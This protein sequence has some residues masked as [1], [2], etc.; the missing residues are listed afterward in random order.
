MQFLGSGN[1]ASMP[2]FVLSPSAIACIIGYFHGPDREIPTPAEDYRKATIDLI[3]PAYNEQN[4]VA[5]CLES[6]IKQTVKPRHIYLIDDGS[7]DQTAQFATEY[8]DD[9]GLNLT[10][11]SKK[12]REGKTPAVSWAAHESDADVLV[13]LDADTTLRSENY[14]ERLVQELYQGVGIACACGVVLPE[15]ERDRAKLLEQPEIQD[16][17]LNHPEIATSQNQGLIRN[18]LLLLSNYYREELYLYLQKFIYHGEMVFFGSII[19]P[20]GCAVAYR[21]QYI[22]DI[23]DHYFAR[24][25]FNLTSSEDIFIGFAFADKGYRNIQLNDVYALTTEPRFFQMPKQIKMWSSAFLQSCY[26]FD[27]LVRTPLKAP[28]KWYHAFKNYLNPM[29]PDVQKRRIIHEAY[30]QSFNPTITK[31]YGRPIG[32]FI[33]TSLLEKISYP[34]I[35]IILMILGY[36]KAIEITVLAEVTIYTIMIGFMH[37]NRRIRNILK[38]LLMTPIRYGYLAFDMLFI[39]NF[40]KELWITKNREWRK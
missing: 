35:L 5:L 29:N 3:I 40:A 17:L 12:T 23:F 18:T 19:N 15:F 21:R 16:F 6:V 7:T 34:T 11:L 30:R 28:K 10:V 24:F 13:V 8:A 31:A 4:N 22:L 33:F 37:K 26:Y 27:D 25:G 38:S 32:W 20:V 9:K 36:W 14:I 39:L 1:M 2:Y